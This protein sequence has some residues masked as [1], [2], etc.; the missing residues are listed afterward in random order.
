MKN[1]LSTGEQSKE[2]LKG[3]SHLLGWQNKS[4]PTPGPALPNLNTLSPAGL[5]NVLIPFKRAIAHESHACNCTIYYLQKPVFSAIER[6][7]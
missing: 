2:E 6:M 3:R 7:I 5:K 1:A 4:R